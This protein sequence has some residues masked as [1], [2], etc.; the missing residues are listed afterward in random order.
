MIYLTLN[1]TTKPCHHDVFNH[2]CIIF[3]PPNPHQVRVLWSRA[4]L[5]SDAIKEYQTGGVCVYLFSD[6]NRTN[7]SF[8]RW[9]FTNKWSMPQLW[10]QRVRND[11][12]R[13]PHLSIHPARWLG[14]EASIL[15]LWET[16]LTNRMRDE[17]SMITWR[18]KKNTPLVTFWKGSYIVPLHSDLQMNKFDP[19]LCRYALSCLQSLCV[20]S[21]NK[22][23]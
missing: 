17:A 3:A 2:G 9:N 11:V 7:W 14:L 10:R 19:T 13:D 12:S 15:S 20:G 5:L 4:G 23:V 6:M 18:C 16:L 8:L 22:M 21:Y 1:K